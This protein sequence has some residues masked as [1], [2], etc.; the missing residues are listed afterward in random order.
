M[1]RDDVTQTQERQSKIYRKRQDWLQYMNLKN[2]QKKTVMASH[3]IPEHVLTDMKSP[4]GLD[5]EFLFQRYQGTLFH[6][7]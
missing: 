3:I 6:K 4:K 7:K 5:N 1:L 2:L